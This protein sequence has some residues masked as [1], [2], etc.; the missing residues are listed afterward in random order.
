MIPSGNVLARI[1]SLYGIV[2]NDFRYKFD[3]AYSAGSV[4]V[5]GPKVLLV[6]SGITRLTVK[7]VID[8]AAMLRW[9]LV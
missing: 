1:E 4:A 9:V 3:S 2:S 6:P 8:T 5:Y 7:P